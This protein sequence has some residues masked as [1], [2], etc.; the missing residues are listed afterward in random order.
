MDDKEFIKMMKDSEDCPDKL[1]KMAETPWQKQVAI[2]FVIYDKRLNH[3]SH[4]ID[5]I[6]KITWGIFTLTAIACIVQVINT[7]IPIL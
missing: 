2:E 1:I 3:N 4:R 5:T 7:I 6:Y